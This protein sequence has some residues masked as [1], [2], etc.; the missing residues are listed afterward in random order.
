MFF[1]LL[2][3]SS[4]RAH[5]VA[6]DALEHT[7]NRTVEPE[8]L[9]D[10]IGDTFVSKS[11]QRNRFDDGSPRVPWEG[12]DFSRPPSRRFRVREAAPINCH[13]DKLSSRAKSRDLVFALAVGIA[14]AAS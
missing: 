12:P 10:G 9:D 3:V 7:L 6:L 1:L 11:K 2:R 14:A 5:G 13:P 4:C 8:Q